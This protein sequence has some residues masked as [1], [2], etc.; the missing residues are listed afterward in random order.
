MAQG[1]PAGAG[2]KSKLS[3]LC[4]HAR[5]AEGVFEQH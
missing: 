2:K 5:F 1:Y 4:L 3:L